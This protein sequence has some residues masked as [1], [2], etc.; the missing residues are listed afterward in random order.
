LLVT[1]AVATLKNWLLACSYSN[2]LKL[3]IFI[4]SL[5]HA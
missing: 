4:Y 3:F 1:M 2:S 5:I